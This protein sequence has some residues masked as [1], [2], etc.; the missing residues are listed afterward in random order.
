MSTND[1]LLLILEMERGEALNIRT[2]LREVLVELD[3]YKRAHAWFV[4]NTESTTGHEMNE[5]VACFAVP[6]SSNDKSWNGNGF[7]VKHVDGCK[8]V[9]ARDLKL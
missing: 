7:D 3:R 4:E 5:C 1:D 8:W 6:D 2:M 9:M